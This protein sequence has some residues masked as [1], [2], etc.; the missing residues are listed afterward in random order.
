MAGRPFLT[1]NYGYIHIWPLEEFEVAT[2]ALFDLGVFLCVLGAVLLA[3]FSLSRMA[4][5]GGERVATTAFDIP[6]VEASAPEEV[7]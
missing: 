7:R 3:L 5:R 4:Q 1:S 2:A 6:L